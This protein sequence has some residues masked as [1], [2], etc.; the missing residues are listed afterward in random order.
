VWYLATN[1]AYVRSPVVCLSPLPIL[2][3]PSV[4][5]QRD[6]N[7]LMV[8]VNKSKAGMDVIQWLVQEQHID[9]NDADDVSPLPP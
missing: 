9:P 2:L 3:H 4:L 8:A 1:S 7:I 6:S 5:S